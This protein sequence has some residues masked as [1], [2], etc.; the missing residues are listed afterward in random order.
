MASLRFATAEVYKFGMFIYPV[1]S[2]TEVDSRASSALRVV[3]VSYPAG[4][5]LLE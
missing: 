4:M 3:M 2:V 5:F 1:R